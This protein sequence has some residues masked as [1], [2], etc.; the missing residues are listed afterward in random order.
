MKLYHFTPSQYGLE[1]IK[2]KRLKIARIMDLNDPFEML[3][4]KLDDPQVRTLL[5]NIKKENNA[6]SGL[7]CFSESWSDPVQWAHYAEQHKGI[8]LGFEVDSTLV[9]KVDYIEDRF[10]IEIPPTIE[11]VNKILL[12]KYKHWVYE[13]EYRMAVGLNNKIGNLYFEY[14]SDNIQLKEIIVGSESSITRKEIKEALKD[15][16][17]PV[18]TFKARPAFK[19]FEI[20]RQKNDHLWK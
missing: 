18:E 20:V 2:N 17:S 9:K 14:F 12:S 3:A 10:E 7:L 6:R 8:C 19:T 11:F 5:K 16:D 1:N 4:V 15:Y 13:K